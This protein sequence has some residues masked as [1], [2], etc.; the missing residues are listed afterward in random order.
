VI[1]M[2]MVRRRRPLLRAAAVGGGAYVMGKR[3]AEQ[4]M[5]DRA[6]MQ[7]APSAGAAPDE[8][9]GLSEQDMQRL[10]QLA[11]LNQEGVIT[12]QELAEQKA[13]ILG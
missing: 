1:A 6:A 12:D 13:R 3:H 5:E 11:K 7:E 9:K 2:P 4:S 10:Q 8:P